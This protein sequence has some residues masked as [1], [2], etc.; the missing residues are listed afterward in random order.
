MNVAHHYDMLIDENN[1]PVHDPAPLKAY[2]DGWD[3]KPFIDAMQLNPSKTVL[4]IGVGTGRLAVKTAPLCAR[5][6]GVDLSPKTI[7]RAK[8]NLESFSN[9]RLQCADFQDYKFTDTFDVVYSSL[10]LFHVREKQ[11]FIT[12]VSSLLNP[13]GR[14]VLSI[15]KNRNKELIYGDRRLELFPDTP[16]QIAEYF[17][18]AGIRLLTCFEVEFACVF[19]GEKE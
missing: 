13:K 7:E 6:F 8:Q 10:T 19:V 2:M 16:E 11:R 15:D 18:Q 3:G 4:E 12:K 1:D 5:F 17:K 14:F 9:V